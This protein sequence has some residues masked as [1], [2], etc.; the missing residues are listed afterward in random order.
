MTNIGNQVSDSIDGAGQKISDSWTVMKF[1]GTSVATAERWRRIVGILEAELQKGNRIL[2][3]CSAI[4]GAT[5]LLEGLPEKAA[6]KKDCSEDVN[7]LV[8]M[9]LNLSR[10]MGIEHPEFLHKAVN[11]LKEKLAVLRNFGYNPNV[12]AEIISTGEFWLTKLAADYLGCRDFPVEWRDARKM[13]RAEVDRDSSSCAALSAKCDYSYDSS[14]V[15]E[16]NASDKS[17]VI[18]PGFVASDARGKTV[19][20]GRGGS[21]TS[22]AYLSA[23]INASKL[24]IWTDVPGLFSANPHVVDSARL[25]S[26]VD[27]EEA[28]YLALYGAKVLHPRSIAPARDAG[29]PI[30]IKWISAPGVPGTIISGAAE[31]SPRSSSSVVKAIS[32]REKLALVT[33][34]NGGENTGSLDLLSRF[35]AALNEQNITIESL[36]YGRGS[37]RATFDTTLFPLADHEYESLRRELNRFSRVD[38]D[39]AV[40]AI[41]LVGEGLDEMYHQIGPALSSLTAE[42]IQH[43]DHGGCGRN[44]TLLID[45]KE[46]KSL[47]RGLHEELVQ[48]GAD[49]NSLGPTWD[50][51]RGEVSNFNESSKQEE[52]KVAI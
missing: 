1:G 4:R 19:I 32:S 39:E 30:Y 20:L 6:G 37:A 2:V 5:D 25:L 38:I 33:A 11:E 44:L 12:A 14:L 22:A 13:L 51:L 9:Y 24:Q 45:S 8:S 46:T 15:E 49:F 41:S 50:E 18:A 31:R 23:K 29:I 48:T 17:I 36:A 43:V 7:H 35:A 26:A 34:E 40:S 47:V 27:Y 10:Q 52:L 21:D 28:E 16:L 3:V 42:R